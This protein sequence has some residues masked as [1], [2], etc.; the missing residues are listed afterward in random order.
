MHKYTK[1][2]LAPEVP[3]H[4]YRIRGRIQ[5]WKGG[6]GGSVE[7]AEHAYNVYA[8]NLVLKYFSR[9]LSRV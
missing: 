4:I 7:S 9:K 5:T 3:E 1:L 2:V 6:E 8:E